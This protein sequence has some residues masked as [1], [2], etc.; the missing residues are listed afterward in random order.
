M[1]VKMRL[2]RTASALAVGLF[3]AATTAAQAQNSGIPA[4]FPPASYTGS[5]YVDSQGCAFV[6]AGVSGNVQWVPRVTRS[7][8]QLCNFQP[9]FATPPVTEAAPVP[10][11]LI[12]TTRPA[13]ATATDTPTP[14]APAVAADVAV[15]A[16][17]VTP[18]P[19][20][21]TVAAPADAPVAT[22]RTVRAPAVIDVAR[23]TVAAPAPRQAARP[24]VSVRT[25]PA[26]ALVPAPQ[27]RMTF[28]EACAG[29]FGVQP[30]FISARTGQPVNC[31]PAPR[32]AASV[33]PV[34]VAVA[35]SAP[36]RR[37]TTLSAIC[38]EMARTGMRYVY[39]DD[40]TP[41]VCA[42]TLAAAQ[43]TCGPDAIPYLTGNSAAPIRCHT[44]LKL[45]YNVLGAQ[46]PASN[47]PARA[48]VAGGHP[49]GYQHV[50]TDGRLNS[51]RAL[52]AAQARV[53]TRSTPAPVQAPAAATLHR[54][55]Q[56]GSFADHA[57]AQRLGQRLMAAGLPV[58]LAN[59][60]A[61][62]VVLAGPFASPD[63]LREALGT[64]RGLGFGDAFTRN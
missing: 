15:A 37:T 33:T 63:A 58:G 41:V 17:V 55:V 52:P 35:V 57:N 34:P 54:Y 50:W 13:T 60:G 64:V 56:V 25:T 5:Q 42:P 53:S 39:A 46:I 26:P 40:R 14:E 43:Q 47:A 19:A 48:V 9:T 38:V 23:P 30:G 4:E 21:P 10:R 51:A 36:A 12:V 3:L 18:P 49:A 61:L 62:K 1:G 20:A 16:P 7:R 45:A 27:R 8:Q 59:A 11:D 24:A 22:V 31:G 32:A 29:K 6:R 28:A 2:T 44:R